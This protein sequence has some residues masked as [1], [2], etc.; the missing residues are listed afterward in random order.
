MSVPTEKKACPVCGEMISS[1]HL[2]W[3]NHAK[4]HEVETV[5]VKETVVEKPVSKVSKAVPKLADSDEQKLMERALAVQEEMAKA[6]ESFVSED[7]TDAYAKLVE[8]YAPDA[9]DKF[10]GNGKL[11]KYAPLHPYFGN[12]DR[13]EI[14]VNNGYMPVV[15]ER[16]YIVKGPGGE[17][18]YTIDRKIS[19]ARTMRCQNE[20]RRR[21]SSALAVGKVSSATGAEMPQEGDNKYV[22]FTGAEMIRKPMG[23]D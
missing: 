15:N 8:V 11:I 12:P 21:L 1:H 2:S 5:E 4:K 14:D 23:D 9:I 18:L 3:A 13:M 6:P 20:S 22:K 16:G 19:D 7:T 10:D 17:P